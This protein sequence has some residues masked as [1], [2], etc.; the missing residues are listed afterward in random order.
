M[1]ENRGDGRS[2]RALRTVVICSVLLLVVFMLPGSAEAHSLAQ[3]KARAVA[4]AQ[5]L[6]AEITAL[7]DQ[8]RADG[9]RYAADRQQLIQAQ[10]QVA[11]NQRQLRQSSR[12]LVIDRLQLGR[13]AVA[14]YMQPSA[15]MLDVVLQADS[16]E[17]LLSDVELM[18]RV[19]AADAALVAQVRD[20]EGVLA[21]VRSRL[22]GAQRQAAQVLVSLASQQTQIRATLATRRQALQNAKAAVRR[23]LRRIALARAAAARAAEAA[24]AQAA[25]DSAAALLPSSAAGAYTPTSWARALLRDARLPTSA[26]NIAAVVAWEMAE[27]GHWLNAARYNPL[28]TTMAEPGASDVNAVGVKAYVSWAQ[29]LAATLATLY[30]GDYGAVVAALQ[31]GDDAQAVAD[32][33]AA[34]PW[35]T[36]P[37][38]V[39]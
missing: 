25:A 37:F 1:V 16:F 24:A 4:R 2:G 32:A 15:S 33:V 8:L 26:A 11:A 28:D 36:L 39:A 19:A 14:I 9:G 3:Q 31:A 29:G 30:D 10:S 22:L 23:I 5:A 6:L 7:D 18:D 38:A 12:Q 35:G 21:T 13:R 34:S 17:Q 27:G 20:A